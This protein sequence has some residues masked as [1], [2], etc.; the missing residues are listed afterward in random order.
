MILNLT[1][2]DLAPLASE[3]K[4]Q[5]AKGALRAL[6]K[7]LESGNKNAALVLPIGGTVVFKTALTVKG[8]LCPTLVA[9]RCAPSYDSEGNEVGL[10]I[11]NIAGWALSPS[12]LAEEAKPAMEAIEKVFTDTFTSPWFAERF[13][14]C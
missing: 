9:C 13:G 7:A 12:L 8:T 10:E 2:E 1:A 11:T 6:E 3:A 5:W 4:S 14:N